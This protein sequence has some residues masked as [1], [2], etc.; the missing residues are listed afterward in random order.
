MQSFAVFIGMSIFLHGVIGGVIYATWSNVMGKVIMG[1]I[2]FIISLVVGISAGIME[3]NDC[4]CKNKHQSFWQFEE[5]IPAFP[6]NDMYGPRPSPSMDK[7]YC[8]V[9][10]ASRFK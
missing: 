7:Y 2:F 1:V 8:S 10:K 4:Y 9:C 5:H 3:R 6:F